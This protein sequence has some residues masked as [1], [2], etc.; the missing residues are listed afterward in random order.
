MA[1]FDIA[2]DFIFGFL[3]DVG[4]AGAYKIIW[5]LFQ[6]YAASRRSAGSSSQWENL[7]AI[8]SEYGWQLK[9]RV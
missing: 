3:T 4:V 7:V 1:S 6:S 2:E 8:D 9:S 5:Q